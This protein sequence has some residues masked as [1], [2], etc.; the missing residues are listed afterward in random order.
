MTEHL[1]VVV[2]DV[3]AD[4]REAAHRQ[5]CQ[6]M[7]FREGSHDPLVFSVVKYV[8]NQAGVESW[9]FPEADVKH[10]DG[11]DRW[12]YALVPEEES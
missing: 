1:V 7:D 10:I 9:W 6:A 3:E 11:N 2:F 8:L 5:F 12:P 4:T